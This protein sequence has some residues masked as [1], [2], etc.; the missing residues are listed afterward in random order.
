MIYVTADQS[1]NSTTE[2]LSVWPEIQFPVLLM[3]LLAIVVKIQTRLVCIRLFAKP[4][5]VYVMCNQSWIQPRTFMLRYDETACVWSDGCI[6]LWELLSLLL[7]QQLSLL[8]CPVKLLPLVW[9]HWTNDMQSRQSFFALSSSLGFK[10]SCEQKKTGTF[11]MPIVM[12]SLKLHTDSNSSRG[13]NPQSV[14]QHWYPLHHHV[15]LWLLAL[16]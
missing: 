5:L 16:I 6:F 10:T 11:T 3:D 13:S 8:L 9:W 7:C 1:Q 12:H 15:T 2:T 4:F 14:R